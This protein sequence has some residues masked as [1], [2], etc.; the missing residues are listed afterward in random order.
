MVRLKFNAR[1]K[2]VFLA[3]GLVGAF[4]LVGSAV[5]GSEKEAPA[6]KAPAA[7]SATPAT[8]VAVPKGD[9]PA[10]MP[11]SGDDYVVVMT[12]KDD[13]SQKVFSKYLDKPE[14][15]RPLADYN[16]LADG[17]KVRIPKAML[18][19]GI[20]PAKITAFSGRVDIARKVDWKWIPAVPNLLVSEGDWIR[21]RDR[22]SAEIRQ[23]DGTVVLLRPGTKLM[24]TTSGLAKTERGEI[25]V[26]KLT[27]E[28]GAIASR[29]TKLRAQDSRFEIK[30]PT[31]TSFI[32]GTEFRVKVEAEGTRLEVLEGAVDFGSEE[33]HVSVASNSGSLAPT[34]AVTPVA[35]SALPER[36]TA[37]LT[38][39]DRQ[40]LDGEIAGYR[41]SWAAAPGATRY[42]VEIAADAE[43]RELVDEQW[44]ETSGADLAGFNVSDLD[45]GTYFWR[46]ATINGAGYESAWSD[47]RHFVYPLRLKK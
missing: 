19:P 18:K 37:L 23:D 44:V 2:D 32:R 47:A 24:F 5:H 34:G 26:T 45:P 25:R 42:H 4:A 38:P 30:T 39:E 40:V 11:S 29:V 6:K 13:S 33:S 16:L 7:A 22:S 8:K 27:L 20:L 17:V 12:D 35:P 36:P 31:A 46:V 14:S 10:T 43:F 9:L 41:F 15:W 21:T 28:S 1:C 3:A